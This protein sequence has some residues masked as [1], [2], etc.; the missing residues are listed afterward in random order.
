MEDGFKTWLI[1]NGRS[2][3]TVQ[4]HNTNIAVL[5]RTMPDWSEQSIDSFIVALKISGKTNATVNSYISTIKH[6]A[7]YKGYK[8]NHISYFKKQSA[9][10]GFLSQEEAE[11]IYK[12]PCPQNCRPRSWQTFSWFFETLCL[13]GCRP[14]E[15]ADLTP[16]K[17][18]FG[19]NVF[20]VEHSKNNK[21]RNLM[22]PPQSKGWLEELV[23]NTKPGDFILK[24]ATGRQ[25]TD[26]SWLQAFNKRKQILGI[27]RTNITPY[28]FRHSFCNTLLEEGVNTHVVAKTMGH[29]IEETVTYEHLTT[30]DICEAMRKHPLIR[31]ETTPKE[32]L[33]QLKE[34]I[35]K[36]H[37]NEDM[38]F[39]F[40]FIETEEGVILDVR[41][42]QG[43]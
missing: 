33:N 1:R 35:R 26:E 28:S 21:V 11:A 22:I 41:V 32:I 18:D 2:L 4:R 6:Y 12:M 27:N 10:K 3:R 38:R 30:K 7:S 16:E 25:L 37:L 40:E 9:V 39:R 29:R 17:I 36:F 31:K 20:V 15:V 14:S 8:I 43:L 13:S 34:D 42:K 23:K 5:L 19:R 24:T